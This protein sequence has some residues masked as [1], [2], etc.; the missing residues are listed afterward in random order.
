MD[1]KRPGL[2]FKAEPMPRVNSSHYSAKYE[3]VPIWNETYIVCLDGTIQAR[4]DPE[5][6]ILW[7]LYEEEYGWSD[8]NG[9]PLMVSFVRW[10]TVNIPEGN[11]SDSTDAYILEFSDDDDPEVSS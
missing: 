6:C 5:R 7:N 3:E 1:L 4:C 2:V 9:N 8:G 11:G 10:E